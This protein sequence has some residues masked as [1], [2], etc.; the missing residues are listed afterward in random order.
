MKDKHLK[1]N[2]PTCTAILWNVD[3]NLKLKLESGN[4]ITINFVAKP[5]VNEFNWQR[6]PQ[7]IILGYEIIEEKEPDTISSWGF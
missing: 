1:V 2:L 3:E 7:L 4:K 5:S 6:I